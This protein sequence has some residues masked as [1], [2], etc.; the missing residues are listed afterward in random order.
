MDRYMAPGGMGALG[1]RLMESKRVWP[2]RCRGRL[3][4][5]VLVRMCDL[6]NLTALSYIRAGAKSNLP[7]MQIPEPRDF[8]CFAPCLRAWRLWKGLAAAAVQHAV[9]P[10]CTG[11]SAKQLAAFW[12]S[13]RATFMHGSCTWAC[14]NCCRERKLNTQLHRRLSKSPPSSR[15]PMGRLIQEQNQHHA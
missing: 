7:V 8:S 14:C 3:G 9:A 12:R 1:G 13:A 2:W 6:H 4:L 5:A 10:H 15:R 11:R